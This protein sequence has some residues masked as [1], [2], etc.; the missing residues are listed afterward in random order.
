MVPVALRRACLSPRNTLRS[1]RCRSL[2]LS[3][4]R[5]GGAPLGALSR[6]AATL[7]ELHLSETHLTSFPAPVWHGVLP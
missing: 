1:I 4:N 6:L 7:R 5:L 3:T 2:Q